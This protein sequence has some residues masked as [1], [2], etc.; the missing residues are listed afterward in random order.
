MNRQLIIAHR[1]ESFIAPE[2]TLSSV[3][4]AWR[5]GINAVE[6]DVRLSK[7]NQVV[8]IHDS[9]T[10]RISRKLKWI[11]Y[12]KLRKLK[13]IDIGIK[14][15]HRY[16]GEVI[17]TLQEVLSTVSKGNKI[18]IEIK[19]SCKIIP[20][21]KTV[22][23]TSSLQSD[24]IEI[25]SFSLKTLIEVR[26]QLSQYSIFWIRE[27]DYYWIRKIFR[28]SINRIISKAIKYNLNGLDLWAGRMLDQHV[29]NEIKSADLKLYAWTVNKPQKAKSLFNMGVD[30]ITT[31]RAGWIKNQLESYN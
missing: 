2:N 13:R 24:Q 7:D 9:N 28:P 14:K 10:W 30:G 19:S 31:D 27:L 26:K 1:G 15:N 11:R 5:N 25:I 17:P 18:I 29:I 22:I 21:L 6:V 8:V 23:N 3:N 12:T 20:Y 4:L 16:K